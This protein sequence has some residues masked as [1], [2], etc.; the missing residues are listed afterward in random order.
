MT[1]WR[2]WS[3]QTG[4]VPL[5]RSS[6]CCCLASKFFENQ[7]AAVLFC[8]PAGGAFRR[9]LCRCPR[10]TTRSGSAPTWTCSGG[11]LRCTTGAS[12]AKVWKSG[13]EAAVGCCSCCWAD[14]GGPPRLVACCIQNRPC[15]LFTP[16]GLSCARRTW[17][18]WTG[19]RAGW[20]LG[21]TRSGTTPCDG[22]GQTGG[23]GSGA[24][25]ARRSTQLLA[26]VA[27]RRRLRTCVSL[28]SS[29]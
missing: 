23:S 9:A 4:F 7:V 19:W 3:L 27:A 5:P 21:G 11:A 10:A 1:S 13:A 29:V 14:R 17:R 24:K 18:R 12:R 16:A 22:L 26:R 25:A 2:R 6:R 28:L 15:C 8:W 20:S